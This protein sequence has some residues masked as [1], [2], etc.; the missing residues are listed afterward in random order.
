MKKPADVARGSSG[1]VKLGMGDLSKGLAK[2]L[3]VQ[4]LEPSL[5]RTPHSGAISAGILF[6]GQAAPTVYRWQAIAVRGSPS[7]HR[8]L[9]T[10][11]VIWNSNDFGGRMGAK[12]LYSSLSSRRLIFF[13]VNNNKYNDAREPGLPRSQPAGRL[14]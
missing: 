14:M 3:S 4:Q 2:K 5:A 10:A 1:H 9:G 11:R 8:S 13:V 12:K 6:N 7:R